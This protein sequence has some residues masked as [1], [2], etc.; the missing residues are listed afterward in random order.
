MFLSVPKVKNDSVFGSFLVR[1]RKKR[2]RKGREKNGRERK[3][4]LTFHVWYKFSLSSQIP[5][6]LGGKESEILLKSLSFQ[7]LPFP[8]T[9][10]FFMNQTLQSNKFPS[11]S[12]L[13]LPNSFYQTSCKRMNIT[14]SKELE[15]EFR[16]SLNH[17]FQRNLFIFF[18]LQ[19]M[20]KSSSCLV[21]RRKYQS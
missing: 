5:P 16:F 12:F 4:F 18:F 13:F 3:K 2:E 9:Y 8:F 14:F 6:L 10:F 15:F 19:T 11:T 21:R 7:F 20:Y 17:N 1:E